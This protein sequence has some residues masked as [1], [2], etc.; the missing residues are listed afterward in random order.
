MVLLLKNLLFTLVVPAGVAVYGPLAIAR[1]T[2]G[3]EFERDLGSWLA[4][5]LLALGTVIYLRCLYDLVAVGRATPFPLDPPRHLVVR[6]LYRRVRNP[7]YLGVF[8][9][10]LGWALW[11]RSAEILAYGAFVTAF[12]HGFVVLVEEP[13]LV[14][15]FGAAYL[16]YRQQVGRWLPGPP[17]LP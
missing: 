3:E 13:G 5:P 6:G 7:M 17:F 8:A 4:V 2:V 14:R 15:R 12:I 1:R 9:A 11:Y 16:S 10:I